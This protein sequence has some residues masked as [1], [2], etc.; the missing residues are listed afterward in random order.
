MGK[1]RKSGPK[2]LKGWLLIP[3]FALILVPLKIL[4]ADSIYCRQLIEEN[5]G[6]RGDIRFWLLWLIDFLIIGFMVFAATYFFRRKKETPKIFISYLFMS[7]M[8]A[9][10]QALMLINLGLHAPNIEV[11]SPFIGSLVAGIVWTL[12]FL[13]SK[14]VK[15]TFVK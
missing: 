15:N 11:F 8:G 4:I 3:A 6:L 7:V 13:K 2:G 5:P 9:L 10:L 1:K 14:R 12:Y